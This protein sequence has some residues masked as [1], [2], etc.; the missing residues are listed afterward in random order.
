MSI[1]SIF[2]TIEDFDQLVSKTNSR[3][4]GIIFDLVLNHTSSQHPWFIQ[5]YQELFYILHLI[6]K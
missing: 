4:I 2:G 6:H 5:S 1:D 3:N